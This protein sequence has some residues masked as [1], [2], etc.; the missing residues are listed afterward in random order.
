MAAP[1]L[2]QLS[3]SWNFLLAAG[4]ALERLAGQPGRRGWSR[5]CAGVKAKGRGH[6]WGR[7]A[8]MGGSGAAG[9]SLLLWS[10]HCHVLTVEDFRLEDGGSH[11]QVQG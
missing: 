11:S 1:P 8:G 4:E 10:S 3:S 5:G 6:R 2:P 7:G 9:H